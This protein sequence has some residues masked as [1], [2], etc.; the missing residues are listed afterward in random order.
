M[1][2]EATPFCLSKTTVLTETMAMFAR[3]TKHNVYPINSYDERQTIN[4]TSQ[5]EDFACEIVWNEYQNLENKTTPDNGRS[6]MVGDMVRLVDEN[7]SET[8]WICCMSGW[9]QTYAPNA[10]LQSVP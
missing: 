2:Y 8:W 9:A 10:V 3:E 6:L 7:D 1:N 4:I 5:D